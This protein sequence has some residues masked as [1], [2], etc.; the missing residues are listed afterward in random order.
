MLHGYHNAKSHGVYNST[1]EGHY[2]RT[3]PNGLAEEES[4]VIN[5]RSKQV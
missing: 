3:V 2:A 4:F 1:V 5:Q